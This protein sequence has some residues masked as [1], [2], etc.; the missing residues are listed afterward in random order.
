MRSQRCLIV[1]HLE[2][3]IHIELAGINASTLKDRTM[4]DPC[5][6]SPFD[7]GTKCGLS[8]SEVW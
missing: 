8:I 3:R 7:A 2:N 6:D 1:W 5:M 4:I